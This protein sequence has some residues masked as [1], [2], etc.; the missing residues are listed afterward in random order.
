MDTDT[1]QN[2]VSGVDFYSADLETLSGGYTG[3]GTAT[4]IDIG[5]KDAKGSLT[6]DR[7]IFNV[8]ISGIADSARIVTATLSIKVSASEGASSPSLMCELSTESWLKDSSNKPTWETR[9]GVANWSALGGSMA[10]DRVLILGHMPQSVAVHDFD[11]TW[12]ASIAHRKHA[13]D[14]NFVLYSEHESVA[15]ERY[16][17]IDSCEGTTKPLLTITSAVGNGALSKTA[18]AGM[19]RRGKNRFKKI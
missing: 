11:L 14:F 1:F 5:R 12:L 13:G 15:A 16:I 3:S 17:T 2:E 8:D 9:N 4:S 7:G 19:S 18:S 10:G 6:T